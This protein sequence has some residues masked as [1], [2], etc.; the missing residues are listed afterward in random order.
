MD[1]LTGLIQVKI[2]SILITLVY[3][4]LVVTGKLSAETF[5]G[6]FLMVIS[7][8]FGQSSARNYINDKENL[9]K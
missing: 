2:I 1:K 6:I 4:F 8:Y 3:C 9:P 7:F 5:E